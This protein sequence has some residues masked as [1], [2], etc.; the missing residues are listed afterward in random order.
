VLALTGL[1]TVVGVS[2]SGWR[3][4]FSARTRNAPEP[5][6]AMQSTIAIAT[7]SQGGRC[8]SHGE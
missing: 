8:W 6:A 4:S 5:E 3:W 2:D 1:T 7:E